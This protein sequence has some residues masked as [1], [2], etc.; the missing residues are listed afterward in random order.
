MINNDVR[1]SIY[2]KLRQLLPFESSLRI[3]TLINDMP[4]ESY[5]RIMSLLQG[6]NA[7]AKV[8]Q[9]GHLTLTVHHNILRHVTG[10]YNIFPEQIATDEK[11]DILILPLQ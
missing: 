9:D 7:V 5:V 2:L 11:G 10:S 4:D 8:D 3:A 1:R 6:Q